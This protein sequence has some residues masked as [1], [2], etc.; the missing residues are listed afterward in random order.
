[1][2]Y[3]FLTILFLFSI[4]FPADLLMAAD[5]SIP[6]SHKSRMAY[7]KVAPKLNREMKRIDAALGD[8]VFIRIFKKEQTLEVWL[9][10]GLTYNKFKSY[11]ICHHSG[12]LGPKLKEGDKQSPE[13]F[14]TVE[15]NQL[16]P[17]SNYHLSFNL[18]FP[19]EYDKSYKR[20]GSLLMVHGKCSSAGCFA[21]ADFRMEEIYAIVESA[22]ISGQH[23]V[24][25]HIFPFKMTEANMAAH[26][27]SKWINFWKNLKQGYDYFEGHHAPPRVTVQD[28]QYQFSSFR[29]FLFGGNLS[30]VTPELRYSGLNLLLQPL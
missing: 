27:N 10:Q 1:M 25:V 23:Q 19:N 11:S 5:S 6:S 22:M 14:Y 3:Y 17:N 30:D 24:P 8:P 7:T 29:S 4:L 9:R 18:G 12:V 16:N 20:T 2:R 21:M 28:R 26:R 15:A 13:G